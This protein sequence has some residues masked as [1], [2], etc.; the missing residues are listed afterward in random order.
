MK[1]KNSITLVLLLMSTLSFSQIVK[2]DSTSY[3][4]KSFRGGLNFNQAAF[5]SNWT[6]GGINSIG[7]NAALNYKANYK[8]D[9]HSWDNTIDLLY[10]FVNNDGQGFRKTLD[11][12]F[13][14]TKYGYQLSEKWSAYVSMNILSQFA[15]GYK[16]E[17]DV[18]GVE[19]SIL[20][21]DFM[22]PG[23]ITN[24]WGFQYQPVDYFFIR[25]SPFSPRMTI[26]R[27]SENYIAVDP[28]R[29][30]GVKVGETTRLEWLAF[31][32]VSE[33]DKDIAKNLNL[34]MRYIMYA[35]YETLELKTIDHRF[36][37]RLTAKVNKF[38]DVNLGGIMLY[39]YDQD[40]GAQF[41]QVF[42]LGFLYSIQ[43]FAPE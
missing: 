19:Q 31:Q 42:S 43:N 35:N 34:G 33:F 41:T 13:I 1:L 29:P 7:F 6:G 27:D 24:S 37:A 5:S 36:E 2:L 17:K 12:I 8:K 14:D 4:K 23:Y 26:V 40:A 30:Y 28:D 20:I 32:L 15:Q 3:W 16:Y 11:R 22:A 25:L 38:I 39:D 9:K 18:N 10:G 21:S